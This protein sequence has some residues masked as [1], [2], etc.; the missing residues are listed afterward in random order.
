M[1]IR[2]ALPVP[3]LQRQLQKSMGK[4]SLEAWVVSSAPPP[5]APLLAGLSFLSEQ[6]ASTE[7][8]PVFFQTAG[9]GSCLWVGGQGEKS[10]RPYYSLIHSQ[11]P[12]LIQAAGRYFI[13]TANITCL[14][15]M[16][17]TVDIT[18]TEGTKVTVD[19]ELAFQK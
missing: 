10:H 13:H 14:P 8:Q 1:D 17:D 16:L 5:A 11:T 9:W 12:S 3:C 6:A 18:C 19:V 2:A 15:G 4:D 7:K